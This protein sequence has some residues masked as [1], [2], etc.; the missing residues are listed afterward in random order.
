MLV[1]SRKLGE[2]IIIGDNIRIGVLAIH[3]N[4]VRLGF[5]APQDVSIRREE[6]RQRAKDVETLGIR[7]DGPC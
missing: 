5:T 4:H 1:L 7:P 3:G 6:L 2:E